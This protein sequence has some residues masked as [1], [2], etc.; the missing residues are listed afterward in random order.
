MTCQLLTVE[1][2]IVSWNTIDLSST[3]LTSKFLMCLEPHLNSGPLGG[4][5]K[6]KS[7]FAFP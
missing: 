3:L 5:G 1:K 4:G 2:T 7:E 6:V